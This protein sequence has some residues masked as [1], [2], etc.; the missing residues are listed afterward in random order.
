MTWKRHNHRP[1]AKSCH[2]NEEAQNTYS[3][4]TARTN[5][6][7]E[8]RSLFLGRIIRQLGMMLRTS[9]LNNDQTQTPTHSVS[10]N[11]YCHTINRVTVLERTIVEVTRVFL[12]RGLFYV[13]NYR[14]LSLVELSSRLFELNVTCKHLKALTR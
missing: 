12:T 9:S 8:T 7:K 5:K 4:S 11:T 2:H 3:Q 6:N 14:D 10:L 13:A 1:Q